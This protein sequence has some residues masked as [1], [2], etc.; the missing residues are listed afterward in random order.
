MR[1]RRCGMS[2][3]CISLDTR[4]RG[5]GSSVLV[6]AELLG[7]ETEPRFTDRRRERLT[8]AFADAGKRRLRATTDGGT[9]VA[10]DLPRGSFLA[11]GAV[12]DDD[13]ERLIVVE[14]KAEEMVVIRLS[15]GP[16]L[17]EQAVAIGNAFGNQHVSV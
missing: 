12:L 16:T 5:G 9:D 7:H 15:H 4:C 17:L 2:P 10:V 11:D 6:V 3:A 1:F 13:G 8:V 14:R